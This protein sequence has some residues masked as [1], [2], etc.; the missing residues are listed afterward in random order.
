MA[1]K[2]VK[3]NT[4]QFVRQ[5]H[6][7]GPDYGASINPKHLDKSDVKGKDLIP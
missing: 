1:D 4:G 2:P 3:K 7:D 6:T 5:G